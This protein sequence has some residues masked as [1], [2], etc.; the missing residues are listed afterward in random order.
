MKY[1]KI[2]NRIGIIAF[3][4]I[5]IVI[6][7]I[8][9]FG[10]NP[11]NE[12]LKKRLAEIEAENKRLEELLKQK[13]A[14]EKQPNQNNSTISPRKRE[15]I[16]NAIDKSIN[17]PAHTDVINVGPMSNEEFLRV[18]QQRMRRVGMENQ[19]GANVRV[20]TS[21]R[22]EGEKVVVSYYMET[23]ENLLNQLSTPR[24]Q[25]KK[26]LEAELQKVKNTKQMYKEMIAALE[27]E[28]AAN[29]IDV[30]D[31]GLGVVVKNADLGPVES[32][33]LQEALEYAR[34]ATV[35]ELKKVYGVADRKP[36]ENKAAE[37]AQEGITLLGEVITLVPG[38]D[39][40]TNHALWRVLS[41]S[42]E[43][44]KM[45]GSGAAN[46]KIYMRIDELKQE[47]QSLTKREL[48]IMTSI[49]SIEN[50]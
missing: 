33:E 38:G 10:Q 14:Q 12:A 1:N 6:T 42:P 41:S 21:C 7:P 36:I 47:Y 35:Q 11:E 8:P 31:N 30:V 50:P 4:F 32:E 25:E 19:S 29:N 46:I 34:Q 37:I 45:L 48:S 17:V 27:K 49:R 43:L 44:G 9:I 22:R 23:T 16:D 18:C 2:K 28:L 20:V 40:V 39:K 24:S 15:Q 13:K 5:A 26:A 3:L